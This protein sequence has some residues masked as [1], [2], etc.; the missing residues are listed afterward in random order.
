[1]KRNLI[2]IC[3]VVLSSIP[4]VRPAVAETILDDQIVKSD[5][6]LTKD[7]S[8]YQVRGV[9][10]IS[11]GITL[12]INPGVSITF[13]KGSGIKN[14]GKV[15]IGDSQSLEKVLLVEDRFPKINSDIESLINGV[16]RSTVSIVNTE[17]R[18]KNQDSLVFGCLNLSN[19]NSTRVGFNRLVY[20]QECQN[21]SL[22]NSYLSNLRYLYTCAFD[23]HPDTFIVK[24]NIFEGP[25]DFCEVL[26]R[27]FHTASFFNKPFAKTIYEVTGNDFEALSQINLPVAYEQ[28]SFTSNNLRK[29]EK[30]KLFS[31]T[32]PGKP[33]ITNL[34][35]NYW[36]SATNESSLKSAVKIID[37]DTDMTLKDLI[38]LTPL[39]SAPIQLDSTAQALR[40]KYQ[41][42]LKAKAALLKKSTIT[43]QKGK[44]T[45]KVTAVKPVCPAG[46]KK[47]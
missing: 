13:Q 26:D 14:Y 37:A 9:L 33:V 11:E 19:S 25:L 39:L 29:V 18:S 2:V 34:A 6:T 20:Q 22:Q 27:T 5:M 40:T 3:L 36:K 42:E 8:P 1:V 15:I 28:Y 44:L 46:Y 23:G 43:C 17:L 12:K 16:S 21:F 4:Q 35:G 30:V 31:F 10:Q 41:Q 24:N 38:V 7:K 45:K 32:I 47:K